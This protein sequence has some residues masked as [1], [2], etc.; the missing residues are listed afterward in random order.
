MLNE[1]GVGT[2]E[3]MKQISRSNSNLLDNRLKKMI[4]KNFDV[5]TRFET[6][7]SLNFGEKFSG[8]SK[9]QG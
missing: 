8:K 6:T 3:S 1:A 4:V 9:A 7:D 5:G 2:S